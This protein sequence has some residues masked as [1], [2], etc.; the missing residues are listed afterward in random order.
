MIKVHK[1]I[2]LIPYGKVDTNYSA[3]HQK[4]IEGYYSEGNRKVSEIIGID[5]GKYGYPV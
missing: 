2:H 1:I 3:E 5:L 4:F